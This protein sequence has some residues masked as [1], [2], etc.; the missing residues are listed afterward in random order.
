M[1]VKYWNFVNLFAYFGISYYIGFCL[2]WCMTA[3]THIKSPEIRT[4]VWAR[5]LQLPGRT[6]TSLTWH[7]VTSW[8]ER[9]TLLSIHFHGQKKNS[10]LNFEQWPT[11]A[12][13]SYMF[14]HYCV[15]FRELV[16]SILPS[17]TIVSK[18]VGGVW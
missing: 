17:Y 3:T 5:D 8:S 7:T 12:H 10:L 16:V 4:K 18:H 11:N 9:T 14:R 6:A 13:S 1:K 2:V 15:N